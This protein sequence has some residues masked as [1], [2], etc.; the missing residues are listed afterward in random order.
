ME[1]ELNATI[2]L[3]GPV[4]RLAIFRVRSGKHQIRRSR[5][6]QLIQQGINVLCGKS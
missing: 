2:D 6:D 4:R 5:A 1:P 3:L